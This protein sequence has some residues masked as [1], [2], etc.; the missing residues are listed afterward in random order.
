MYKGKDQQSGYGFIDAYSAI[1]KVKELEKN[2]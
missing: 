1:K 2:K